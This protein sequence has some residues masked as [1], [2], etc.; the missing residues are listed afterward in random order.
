MKRSIHTWTVYKNTPELIP[1][2]CGDELNSPPPSN[3]SESFTITESS[4][5]FLC[6]ELWRRMLFLRL[7]FLLDSLLFNFGF[8]WNTKDFSQLSIYLKWLQIRQGFQCFRSLTSKCNYQ[9]SSL[10][11]KIHVHCVNAHKGCHTL[12]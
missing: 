8:S 4:R 11:R 3:A 9:N 7:L 12:L 10:L 5:D 6:L 1:L 2:G